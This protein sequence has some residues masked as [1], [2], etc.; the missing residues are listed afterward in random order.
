LSGFFRADLLYV[1]A[2]C[3]S[4]GFAIIESHLPLAGDRGSGPDPVLPQGS[5]GD[6]LRETNVVGVLEWAVEKAS[7]S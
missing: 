2:V 4:H 6:R 7:T 5:S 1:E 3:K